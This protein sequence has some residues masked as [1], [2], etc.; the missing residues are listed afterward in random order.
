MKFTHIQEKRMDDWNGSDI[1]TSRMVAVFGR[2]PQIL[3]EV[4]FKA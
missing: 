3:D 2:T 1:N 4:D